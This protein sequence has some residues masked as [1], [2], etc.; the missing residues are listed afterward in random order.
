MA[1][2]AGNNTELIIYQLIIR[3]YT[4]QMNLFVLVVKKHSVHYPMLINQKQSYVT[5]M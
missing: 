4:H 3:G 2:S 1:G 5:L